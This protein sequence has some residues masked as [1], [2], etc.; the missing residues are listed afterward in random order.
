[1]TGGA[2]RVTARACGKPRREG[3]LTLFQKAGATAPGEGRQG[4]GA[5]GTTL[6]A[7]GVPLS[8]VPSL[9]ALSFCSLAEA[10][11]STSFLWV[12]QMEGSYQSA[13]TQF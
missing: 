9:Q 3:R 10:A 13:L 7:P 11:E 8:Q 12:L 6:R 1:M 4:W 5:G 2:P